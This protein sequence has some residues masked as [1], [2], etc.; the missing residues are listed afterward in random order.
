MRVAVL[1]N[2]VSQQDTIEDL[3]VLV[4]V[5][6]VSQSLKRLGHEHFAVACT[7]D[8][9]AMKEKLR[10]L[11][12][13]MVFNLVEALH[14]DDS[15]V[16]LPPA[17]LVS[18]NLPCTGASAESL[19]L[20]THKLLAKD[21]LSR[22]G[23]PT[24][25]WIV[26]DKIIGGDEKSDNSSPHPSPLPKGEGTSRP[27]PTN[28]RS[29]PGEGTTAR[30]IIK[31]VWEQG[32]RDMDDDAVFSGGAAEV[33][34]RLRERVKHTGRPAFAEEYIEGR[35]FNL[36]ML[37]GPG[38]VEVL[39]PAE[40]D[41]SAFPAEKPRIVG[42]RA[43]WQADSFEYN[44][45]PHRFDF[46]DADRPLLDCLADL[47]LQCWNLFML[48]GWG[49][50]DFRVDQSGRPWILEVNANPCLSPDAGFAAALQRA[51]IEFDEAIRRIVD[52]AKPAGCNPWA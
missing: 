51:G 46:P 43:K 32:S 16:Y 4:Q 25:R 17:V 23:L 2:A 5:E 35:E 42:Y 26:Q 29:V 38:P 18:L 8:L 36:A 12:P 22:A 6:V 30:W 47:A 10:E 41:F 45:T 31:G 14:G 49:R 27:D 15:L 19:F 21:R 48:C 50:V 3:D 52:E 39:P 11:R 33:H 20:T 9:D 13:D 37:A 1:Y 28:L 24:P 40:V 7:L 44:N 34:R